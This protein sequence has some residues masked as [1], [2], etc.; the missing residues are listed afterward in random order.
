M[1]QGFFCRIRGVDGV[2]QNCEV[3]ASFADF[4]NNGFPDILIGRGDG[5]FI[6]VALL[7]SWI[8]TSASS[9]LALLARKPLR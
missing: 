8:S 6:D 3:A 9:T 7:A 1:D 2:P 5:T 4:D